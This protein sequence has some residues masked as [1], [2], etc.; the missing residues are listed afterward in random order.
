MSLRTL[1]AQF[2]EI[3]KTLDFYLDEKGEVWA[4][5]IKEDD[6]RRFPLK[7]LVIQAQ[8]KSWLPLMRRGRK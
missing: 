3:Q 1:S 8:L 5:F 2:I 6:Q 7:S 4:V